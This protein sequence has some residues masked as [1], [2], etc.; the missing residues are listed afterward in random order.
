[1]EQFTETNKGKAFYAGL[2]GLGNFIFADYERN[3]KRR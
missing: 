2:E 1:V 3:K